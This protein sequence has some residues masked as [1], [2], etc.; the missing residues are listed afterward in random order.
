ML[1][2]SYTSTLGGGLPPMIDTNS[3]T[4]AT[5]AE[6]GLASLMATNNTNQQ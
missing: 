3:I 4:T 5:T 2:N 6:V 1:V